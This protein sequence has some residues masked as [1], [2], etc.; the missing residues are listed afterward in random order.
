MRSSSSFSRRDLLVGREMTQANCRRNH[1]PTN[2]QHRNKRHS[3]F[4]MDTRW[5]K[6]ELQ[7][8]RN[9]PKW[10]LRI[11]ADRKPALKNVKSL[12]M[13]MTLTV[14]TQFGVKGSPFKD[15]QVTPTAY[16][17]ILKDHIGS[18]RGPLEGQNQQTARF[19]QTGNN[20]RW[21]QAAGLSV[22][23]PWKPNYGRPLSWILLKV[24][25]FTP[26]FKSAFAIRSDQPMLWFLVHCS[27][28]QPCTCL[29][30][31]DNS[32]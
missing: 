11:P 21:K 20:L 4:T 18:L 17:R 6:D 9:D 30:S 22:R 16:N 27:L 5:C 28:Q 13:S 14:P 25:T 2:E 26:G 29:G 31:H 3:L 24:Q 32:Q 1:R 15:A 8:T 7:E 10:T 23:E 19:I 12:H